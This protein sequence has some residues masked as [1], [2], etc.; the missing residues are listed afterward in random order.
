MTSARQWVVILAVNA[1]LAAAAQA[2][3]PGEPGLSDREQ[4][5]Y[6]GRHGLEPNC[7]WSVYC[8]RVLV[9]MA[10]EQVPANAT[11][12]WRGYQVAS[13]TLAG[14]ILAITTGRLV[15]GWSTAVIASLIVQSSFGFTFTAYDPYTADSAVFVFAAVLTWCWLT[16]RIGGAFA[17]GMFGVFAKETVALVS[18]STAI[19]AF[20]AR[21][22]RHWPWWLAQAAVVMATL[23]GFHWVMDTYFGWSITTNA[24]AKF[25]EGSWLAIWWAHNPSVLSKMFYLFMPFGFGWLYALAGFRIAPANL[26]QL[27]LGATAPML[28][29]NYVQNPE[30]ALGNAFFIVVPLAAIALARV[31]VA[32]ALVAVVT[33][34]AITAKVGTS[35]N[36]LPSVSIMLGPAAVSAALVGWHLWVTEGRERRL[37]RHRSEITA[38]TGTGPGHDTI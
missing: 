9:P 2:V 33:N 37:G 20:V 19:A 26:R 5:E 13:N 34:G 18:A 11:L 32:L 22:P 15:G 4:Y 30:R 35:T 28:A 36:W 24:A 38:T 16:N 27:A 31:P 21:Q 29:L 8:Y 25:S 7:G 23:L 10:L 1:G 12:R 6:V 3:V 14:T 17:A